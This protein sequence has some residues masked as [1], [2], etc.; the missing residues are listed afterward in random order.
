[1]SD[2]RKEYLQHKKETDALIEEGSNKWVETNIVLIHEKI[3]RQ[4][5]RRLSGQIKKFDKVFGPF[6]EKLPAMA[7]QITRAEEG[8]QKIVTG[9]ANEQKASNLLK[10]LGYL[11]NNFSSYF[12]SDLPVILDTPLMRAAEANPEVKLSVIHAPGHDPASI[13]DAFKHGLEPSKEEAKLLRK[14]YRGKQPLINSGDIANQMLNL[15]FNELMELTQSGQVPM[16]DVPEE[17]PE[18]EEQAPVDEIPPNVEPE[19]LAESS[20][21]CSMCHHP[22]E[23]HGSMGCMID[24]CDCNVYG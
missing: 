24:D 11:Y 21:G 9:K 8:L 15:S 4:T 12:N 10:Q 23:N 19:R 6:K 16:I 14:I 20:D 22:K 7:A 18:P 13:R 3:D 17:M 5:V 2:L 1:M